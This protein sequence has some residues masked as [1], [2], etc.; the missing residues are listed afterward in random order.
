MTALITGLV[1]NFDFELC[2]FRIAL[3]KLSCFLIQWWVPIVLFFLNDFL[4]RSGL[5]EYWIQSYTKYTWGA[6][7]W[8]LSPAW[9]TVK[10]TA[11]LTLKVRVNCP[12]VV[13]HPIY[14]GATIVVAQSLCSTNFKNPWIRI[15]PFLKR[16]RFTAALIPRLAGI[17]IPGH[18]LPMIM[19]LVHL[20]VSQFSSLSTYSFLHPARAPGFAWDW[21]PL[22]TGTWHYEF[23][24]T[25]LFS[26]ALVM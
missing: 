26:D 25:N 23:L 16:Q 9:D 8:L 22:S 4:W 2:W 12:F 6:L 18:F 3:L 13:I 15:P 5:L 19:K 1:V 20:C 24:S 10:V 7:L 21:C 14:L 11:K 17:N